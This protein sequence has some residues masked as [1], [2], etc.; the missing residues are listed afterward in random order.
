[1]VRGRGIRNERQ[2][3]QIGVMKIK[4]VITEA[5]GSSSLQGSIPRKSGFLGCG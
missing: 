2:E 4:Y 1:M 3:R 5:M